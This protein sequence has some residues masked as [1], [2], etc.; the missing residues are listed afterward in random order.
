[1]RA[2]SWIYYSGTQD[3][4][5]PLLDKISQIERTGGIILQRANRDRGATARE[6]DDYESQD[7]VGVLDL[8]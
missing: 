6:S 4:A 1:M 2:T 5:I 3:S 7:D 8:L